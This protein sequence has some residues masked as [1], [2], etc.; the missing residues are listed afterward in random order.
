MRNLNLDVLNSVLDNKNLRKDEEG[1]EQEKI[2]QE[3]RRKGEKAAVVELNEKKKNEK[4]KFQKDMQNKV[5]TY[6]KGTSIAI[7]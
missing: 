3:A 4:K 1:A 5:K 6:F 2:D 7:V